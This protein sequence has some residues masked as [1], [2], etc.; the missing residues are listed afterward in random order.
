[1]KGVAA[2]LETITLVEG[3]PGRLLSK[4]DGERH[5]TDL[6]HVGQLLHAAAAAERLGATALTGWLRQRI[7]AAEQE[8]GDEERSR[9]LESDAEAVQVLTI[10][11]SK[12]LEF[13]VVYFPYLWEPTWLGHERKEPVFFH[14]PDN[15]D[16]RTIDV[17]LDGRAFDQHVA[18]Y[19][20]EARGEDLRLAYVALT[21]ARHQAVVWWAGS[22]NAR[23]S[24]LSRLLFARGEDGTVAPKGPQ[25]PSD[26]AA[27]TR[28]N[29]LAAAAP[30]RRIGVERS[31]LEPRRPWTG[32]ARAPGE[33][34]A[35]AFARELDWRWRRTSFSDITAGAYEARVASEPEEVLLSDEPD[36]AAPVPAAAN[37][38]EEALRDVPAVLAEMGVGVRVGTLVHRVLEAADFAA[39][40]LRAELA[41]H[42]AE[43]QS[44]RRVEIGDP[45]HV[46]AGLAAAIETPLGPLVG[47]VR[48][49]DI[50]RADR[51]DEL[52]FELPLVGGDDPTGRLALDAIAAVLGEHLP[53][54]DPLG[55]YAARLSDPSLRHS[56]RGFLTGSLDLVLRL[57]GNRFAVADHKT[58][59]LAAP[60]DSLTAWH[61]RP[62]AL[63]AEME[64]AHYGLQAL[65]YT[66]ALHRY[67][68]WRLPGYDP[69]VNLA[70]VL[71][72]FLRGMT[73]PD[74]PRVD[75]APCGVFA[76]KPPGAL[77]VAL[78]DVLDRGGAA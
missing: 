78:S 38:G 77:V 11:R 68:R 66:V 29:E 56:V 39:A 25:T 74:V 45:A 1:V 42:V 12:G 14:D 34:D 62:S 58:N 49:R 69:D 31:V 13:P 51:L 23:D 73:G 72:L 65:L 37:D 63:A 21:R 50:A 30:P 10:H 44:R 60:G 70:G 57:D 40:D 28:L 35:A 64:H 54:G 15:D 71:Y 6:R 47:D 53:P 3:L 16:A 36:V 4:V 18:Q 5:L 48:L 52:S 24:A 2:L 19:V 46:V 33:L 41:G 32:V 67:L 76:W 26:L 75:G 17:A 27:V 22:F 59:W 43:A 20:V 55:G 8:T 61:H 9:R 7:A